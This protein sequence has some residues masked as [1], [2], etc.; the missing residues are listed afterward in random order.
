[1]KNINYPAHYKVPAYTMIGDSIVPFYPFQQALYKTEENEDVCINNI[2]FDKETAEHWKKKHAFLASHKKEKTFPS[3]YELKGEDI[4]HN[5]ANLPQLT[6]EITDTCNLRCKYCGYGELYEDHDE[7]TGKYLDEQMTRHLLDYLIDLWNSPLNTSHGRII[8]IS[9]YGGEPLMNMSFIKHTVDYLSKKKLLYN[10]IIYSMTTNAVL[11]KTNI[12]YLVE[13]KFDLLI[14]LDGNK[15]NNSYRVFP[16]GKESF[17]V[18]KQNLDYV[19][20]TYPEYFLHHINFNSVLH[21]RNSVAEI[22]HYIK[23]TFDKAPAIAELN[24]NGIRKEKEDE[25][26]KTYKN[27]RESLYQAE[28]YGKIKQDMFARLGEIM[29]VG[30]FMLKHSGNIYKSYNDFFVSDTQIARTPTGTCSPFG[31]KMFV[32]VNGKV[33]TCERIGQQYGVGKI[34]PEGVEIDCDEIAKK[35][36]EYYRKMSGQCKQCYNLDTCVQCIYNMGNIDSK[37]ICKGYMNKDKFEQELNFFMYYLSENPGLYQQ[38]LDNLI[39]KF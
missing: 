27:A 3:F 20:E 2:L 9:F 30:L 33:L 5:L 32:T 19:K 14:S 18:I 23:D 28:D 22:Y 16:N 11:L 13:H 35:Y 31:K 39:I 29:D 10:R 1:M 21:N 12:A 38:I 4:K 8:Y 26:F 34:T 15:T 6:L 37:P 7:R 24:N 17:D 25:F 36:N